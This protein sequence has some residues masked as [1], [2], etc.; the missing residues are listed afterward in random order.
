[1][2]NYY[3][4]LI[5]GNGDRFRGRK[6]FVD[7]HK[8]WV[9]KNMLPTTF[10]LYKGTKFPFVTNCNDQ[11]PKEEFIGKL[12]AHCTA[13]FSPSTFD[14]GDFLMIYFESGNVKIQMF[15]PHE[16]RGFHKDLLI[17]TCAY[18]STDGSR[19]NY[20]SYSDI[21]GIY[22]INHLKI[23]IDIYY[24]GNLVAQTG[25]EDGMTF[26]G[27]SSSTVF[28]DN[29]R[30]GFKLGDVLT[31]TYSLPNDTRK[32]FSLELNDNYMN[33]IHVGVINHNGQPCREQIYSYRI[34][35]FSISG[36]NYF[37]P[38]GNYETISQNPDACI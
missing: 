18:N 20:T 27:G 34:N 17:G 26:L 9:F 2:D 13:E 10:H 38:V 8:N 28:F 3:D 19:Q 35:E 36:M 32:M 1:M 7:R 25:A 31:F 4:L 37:L 16:L 14:D 30:Q 21:S 15:P 6:T 22:I 33:E 12:N 24:R 29:N 5:D 11:Y 23:P